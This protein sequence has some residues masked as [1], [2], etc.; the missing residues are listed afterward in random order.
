M[1]TQITFACRE[2]GREIEWK[3]GDERPDDVH[4]CICKGCNTSPQGSEDI[5]NLVVEMMGKYETLCKSTTH[6][7]RERIARCIEKLATER[8]ENELPFKVVRSTS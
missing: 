5:A 6:E 3:W 4:I 1:T 7:D 8:P 2:C